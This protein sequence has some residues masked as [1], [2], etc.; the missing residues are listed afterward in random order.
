MP[1][2]VT[3][4][5]ST[6]HQFSKNYKWYVLFILTLVYALNFFDRQLI[7]ILQEPIKA[8]LGLSDTQLGL[9]SGFAFAIFYCLVGVPI[10][11][12]ADNNNRRNVVG[13]SL[14]VWSFM[15]A[16]TGYVQSFL[17]IF[18]VRI[19]VGVGEAGGNPASHAMI[20][21]YFPPQKRATA[22]AIYATGIYIGLFLGFTMGGVLESAFGWRK[23]FIYLGLPGIL[24]AIF[25]FLTVKEPPKGYSEKKEL[26]EEK[27]SFRE[28]L[29]FLFSRKT[30]VFL[31]LG[32][33]LHSFVGY[34]FAN[35]MPSFLIRVHGM[36]LIEAGFWLAISVGIGG[37]LG[38]FSGGLIVDKLAKRDRRW[39]VWIS[40]VAIIVTLPFSLYT[41]FSDNT[42]AAIICYFIPNVLF[43]LNMG[44]IITVAHGI[45]PVKMRAM[46]SAVYYLVINIVG[47]GFGPLAVGALSDF[48]LPIYGSESLRYSLFFVSIIYSFSIYFFYKAA[49]TLEW[50]LDNALG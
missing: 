3:N 43:A 41:L 37:A 25:L 34:G 49:Q 16:I 14:A 19:G 20:S 35:W 42:I 1:K 27:Q 22:F 50:D 32:S 18:L 36:T 7:V 6:S 44:P 10:A 39:Y 30:F 31:S 15:T 46:T 13:I 29:Q 5:Q 47:L 33:A 4:H 8:D 40:I 45:V 12:Y 21:D 23:A 48:L 11:R 26:R 2:R 17:H 24:F 28:V 9:L 38:A